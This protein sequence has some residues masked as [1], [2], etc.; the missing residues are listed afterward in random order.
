MIHR[1]FNAAIPQKDDNNITHSQETIK[2]QLKFAQ[3]KSHSET[4]FS[5]NDETINSMKFKRIHA[6]NYHS[7]SLRNKTNKR[8]NNFFLYGYILLKPYIFKI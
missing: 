8:I 4:N 3:V 6:V 7:E 2:K 1:N 5:F